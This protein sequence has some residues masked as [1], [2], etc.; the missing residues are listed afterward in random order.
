M[1]LVVLLLPPTLVDA[2]VITWEGKLI[3][4]SVSTERLSRVEFSEN[5]RSVFLSRSDFAVEKEE[6]SLYIRALAPEIEDTLFVLGESGTTYG[7]NLSV[8]DNPDQTIVI[9]YFPKSL[10]VQTERARQVP[11]LDLLR[12]MMR[13]LPVGWVRD[14]QSQ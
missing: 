7:L 2:K 5:L 9:S 1:L 10:E 4:V 6:K 12:S 3:S 14:H 8:S 11:S 13:A